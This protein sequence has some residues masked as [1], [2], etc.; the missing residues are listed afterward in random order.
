MLCSEPIR[1]MSLVRVYPI[2]YFAM[3]DSGAMD[4]KILA[5]PF[6]DPVNNGY[7]DVNELPAHVAEE[8]SHFFNVYKN[9]EKDKSTRLSACSVAMRRSKCSSAAMIA[10][11]INSAADKKERSRNSRFRERCLC[12]LIN[13]SDFSVFLNKG[14]YLIGN[15]TAD[16][17]SL[18]FVGHV[19]LK[20]IDRHA[21]FAA[22]HGDRVGDDCS[23]ASIFSI[24]A[25]S[26]ITCWRSRFFFASGR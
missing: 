15:H 9:L 24:W 21:V 20:L 1:P 22:E 18:E 16:D 19:R 3:R 6:G 11:S 17:C 13:D 23:S 25:I 14:K 8:I 12:I 26:A 2:G 4:E 10:T 7:H 5:I